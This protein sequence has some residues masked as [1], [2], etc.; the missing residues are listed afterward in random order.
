MKHFDSWQINP[1]MD[2]NR[3]PIDKIFYVRGY[4]NTDE[5]I[6]SYM[7]LK[8]NG[9]SHFCTCEFSHFPRDYKNYPDINY[10]VVQSAC[11]FFHPFKNPYEFGIMPETPAFLLSSSDTMS[12]EKVEVKGKKYDF[13]FYAQL[14][15]MWGTD[16]K[17]EK[18]AVKFIKH[19][20]YDD[21]MRCCIIGRDTFMEDHKLHKNPRVDFLGKT[22]YSEVMK[23]LAES[24]FLLMTSDF[25]A[26]PRMLSESMMQDTP[27]LCATSLRG[28]WK[29]INEQTG[30]FFQKC[31]DWNYI[32]RRI[33]DLLDSKT[34][35]PR[36][37]YF[38]HY[39]P[40]KVGRRA[41]AYLKACCDTPIDPSVQYLRFCL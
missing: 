32:D 36:K 10:D 19:Y 33:C 31:E 35:R 29:Y 37:Y 20:C 40:E 9:Y 23:K 5:S 39:G 18:Y 22:K 2:Q 7:H 24:K 41:L 28:G 38:E 8:A 13:L 30:V 27:I 14:P 25:D 16:P 26:S 6:D 15:A 1:A 11:C 4:L 21:N 34:F 17:D 3:K 12:K